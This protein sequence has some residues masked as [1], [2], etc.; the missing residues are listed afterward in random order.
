MT[1]QPTT[2][3]KL[4]KTSKLTITAMIGVCLLTVV[5]NVLVREWYS[6]D[7]RYSIG[8]NYYLEDRVAF[9]C[10]IK[11]MGHSTAKNIR[12]YAVFQEPLIGYQVGGNVPAKITEGGVGQKRLDLEIDRLVANSNFT[13]FYSLKQ[14]QTEPVIQKIE[15]D[16]GLANTGEPNLISGSLMVLVFLLVPISIYY[17]VK[18]PEFPV[19]RT[20]A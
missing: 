10:L 5:L 18:H 4:S 12:V 11:N 7:L 1:D 3:E 15:S 9:S 17:S 19:S 8:E 13:I 6:P 16:D 20:K 2:S 14:A